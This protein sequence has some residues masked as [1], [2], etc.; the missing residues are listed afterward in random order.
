M[1]EQ[2]RLVAGAKCAQ[3]TGLGGESGPEDG[4]YSNLAVVM[5]LAACIVL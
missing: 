1:E 2:R 3:A 5:S 4:A